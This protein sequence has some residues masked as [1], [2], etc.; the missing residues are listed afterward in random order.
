VCV[1]QRATPV[2]L[3]LAFFDDTSVGL[4]G[5]ICVNLL[6]YNIHRGCFLHYKYRLRGEDVGCKIY[7][8][9]YEYH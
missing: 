4:R 9:I 1:H 3:N 6:F 2:Q 7:R 8:L 5:V